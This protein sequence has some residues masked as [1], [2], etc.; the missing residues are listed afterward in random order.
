VLD[1]SGVAKGST[2]RHRGGCDGVQSGTEKGKEVPLFVP[3]YRPRS[4]QGR[5]RVDDHQLDSRIVLDVLWK[6]M[7]YRDEERDSVRSLVVDAR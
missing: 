4:E 7:Q 5:Q 3:S 1:A 6:R 2:Y